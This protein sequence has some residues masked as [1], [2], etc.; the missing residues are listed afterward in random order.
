MGK[1]ARRFDA[2][3]KGRIAASTAPVYLDM[4]AEG[5]ARTPKIREGDI[6]TITG[7]RVEFRE[8][9]AKRIQRDC[10]PGDETPFTIRVVEHGE[11]VEA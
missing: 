11:Q 7:V 8:D 9:G 2:L 5:L 3:R 10:A 4:T 1:Y 6:I